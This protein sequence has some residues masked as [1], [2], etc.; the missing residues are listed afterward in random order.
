LVQPAFAGVA[1]GSTPL[2]PDWPDPGP[3]AEQALTELSRSSRGPARRVSEVFDDAIRATRPLA[4]AGAAESTCAVA[5]AW[6]DH[7]RVSVGV[8]G[9]CL[10][11]LHRSDGSF[12][13]LTDP[14]I[15]RF[16][17]RAVQAAE[18]DQLS[19]LQANRALANSAAGYWIYGAD[20]AAAEHAVW[21][22]APIADIVAI[23]LCT[24]GLRRVPALYQALRNQHLDR[25][26]PG[27]LDD[28]L[29]SVR[30][31]LFDGCVV[32]DVDDEAVAL[33]TRA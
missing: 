5:A 9:D 17:E 18:E 14:S 12:T 10:A 19:V 33:V 22:S 23:F 29:D 28:V 21:T 11:L 3:L 1:D 27:F 8:L 32:P 25:P 15:A 7:D 2:G 6:L 20:P 16:D 31:R 24:D 30:S 13:V 26:G 4:T